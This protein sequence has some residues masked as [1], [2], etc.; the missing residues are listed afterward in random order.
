M[1]P[2]LPFREAIALEKRFWEPLP[3]D[4]SASSK[5]R[6]RLFQGHVLAAED[7]VALGGT[8]GLLGAATRNME[9]WGYKFEHSKNAAGK[10]AIKLINPEHD[11]TEHV[12]KASTGI[13]RNRSKGED[14]EKLPRGWSPVHA[15]IRQKLIDGEEVTIGQSMAMGASSAF[16]RK[17]VSRMSEQGYKVGSVGHGVDRKYRV[18]QAP[19][20][21]RAAAETNGNGKGKALAK[22]NGKDLANRTAESMMFGELATPPPRLGSRPRVIGMMLDEEDETVKIAIKDESG[23][24]MTRIEG[25]V[26][27]EA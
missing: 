19:K 6:R 2:R 21:K 25:Y 12:K 26:E 23:T 11:P 5:L 15:E 13:T 9:E 1:P 14:G 17:E 18:M 3:E 24:W 10:K 8:N 7:G 22:T 4:A 27:A 16:L 20:Q